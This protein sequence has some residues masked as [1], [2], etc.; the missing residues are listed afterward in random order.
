M[1]A[2]GKFKEAKGKNPRSERFPFL[3][4]QPRTVNLTNLRHQ[5]PMH[6]RIIAAIVEQ[7]Q[8]NAMTWFQIQSFDH[9]SNGSKYLR[10]IRYAPTANRTA[11]VSFGL[12]SI[13][14]PASPTL[15]SPLL[16]RIMGMGSAVLSSGGA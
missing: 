3:V 10:S 12:L 11:H 9:V 15:M 2:V 4:A 6:A 8:E 5:A 14:L 16:G 13:I 1:L 7:C